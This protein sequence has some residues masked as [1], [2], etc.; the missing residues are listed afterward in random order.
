M[1]APFEPAQTLGEA[2][3]HLRNIVEA[4]NDIKESQQ[5]M[6][7]AIR[8]EMAVHYTE[9]HAKID[10]QSPKSI[11][12]TMTDISVGIAAMAAA[13]GVVVAVVRFLYKVG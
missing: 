4:L 13:I 8:K 5:E 11:W 9:L 10:K 7:A 2:N 12:K 3:I 6:V 1:I